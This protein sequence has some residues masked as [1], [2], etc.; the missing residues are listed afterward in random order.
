MLT[1]CLCIISHTHFV[2]LLC[3]FLA[4]SPYTPIWMGSSELKTFSSLC[5][6]CGGIEQDRFWCLF[7][8]VLSICLCQTGALL[9][10]CQSLSGL[11][12]PPEGLNFFSS[13]HCLFASVTKTQTTGSGEE[14]TSL[15]FLSFLTFLMRPTLQTARVVH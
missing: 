15:T 4:F 14:I 8:C 5:L 11:S 12:S 9:S 7:A 10:C 3:C 13:T 1:V 2:T 6:I